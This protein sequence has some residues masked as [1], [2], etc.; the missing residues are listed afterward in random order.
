VL[1]LVRA[2]GAEADQHGQQR[3]GTKVDQTRTHNRK[4]C[5]F[6]PGADAAY[7]RHRQHTTGCAGPG[8][9]AGTGATAA[10]VPARTPPHTSGRSGPPRAFA[11]GP[12]AR[13][14]TMLR[15]GRVSISPSSNQS[16]GRRCARRALIPHVVASAMTKQCKVCG[17]VGGMG[18]CFLCSGFYYCHDV[19]ATGRVRWVVGWTVWTGSDQTAHQSGGTVVQ[20]WVIGQFTSS[21]GA[22]GGASTHTTAATVGT[23]LVR[24]VVG[25]LTAFRLCF[26]RLTPHRRQDGASTAQTRTQGARG[27]H[28]ACATPA[29]ARKRWAVSWQQLKRQDRRG[30]RGEHSRCRCRCATTSTWAA[31]DRRG[32]SHPHSH[33]RTL[34]AVPH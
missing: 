13:H 15:T 31:V 33:A 10:P 27:L 8:G 7:H 34:Y 16:G 17:L 32:A 9:G 29:P 26:H 12:P 2:A 24:R 23:G 22:A 30:A 28:A 14:G 21:Q 11:R 6:G 20:W 25:C 1:H 3:K 5:A 19:C 4:S 18:G